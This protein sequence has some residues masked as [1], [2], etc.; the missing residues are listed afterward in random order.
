[1]IVD[2]NASPFGKL[3]C[4]VPKVRRRVC[5]RDERTLIAITAARSASATTPGL[6]RRSASRITTLE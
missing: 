4:N 3:L 1:M 5:R 6:C 2:S